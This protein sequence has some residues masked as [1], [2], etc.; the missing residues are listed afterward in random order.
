M[1]SH[2]GMRHKSKRLRGPHNKIPL[3]IGLC[4]PVKDL[5]KQFRQQ[6]KMMNKELLKMSEDILAQVEE[7]GEQD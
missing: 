6:N 2:P 4:L 5:N 3:F 1:V 7:G